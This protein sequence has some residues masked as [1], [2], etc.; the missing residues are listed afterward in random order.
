MYGILIG[1]LVGRGQIG[2]ELRE[3]V[4][5]KSKKLEPFITGELIQR[6]CFL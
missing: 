3:E 6:Q 2:L 4:W 1:L 5:F